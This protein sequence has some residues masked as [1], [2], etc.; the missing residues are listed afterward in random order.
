MMPEWL[1][2]HGEKVKQPQRLKCLYLIVKP[3]E[4]GPRLTLGDRAVRKDVAE[5]V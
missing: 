3:L 1:K 5:P 2:L 4:K